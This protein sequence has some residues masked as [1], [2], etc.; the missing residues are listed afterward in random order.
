M[1]RWC[2]LVGFLS[3][4]AAKAEAQNWPSFRGPNGSGI[5]DDQNLPVSW[6]VEDSTNVLWK[7]PI[8][9]L[10]H[11]S[12][13]IWGDQVFLTTAI[14][15]EGTADLSTGEGDS[16]GYTSSKDLGR[17]TWLIYGLDKNTGKTLWQAA[18][19]DGDL[20]GY[21]SPR[22]IEHK[23]LR[24]VL[25]LTAKAMIGVNA[26]TGQLLWR[27]PHESYADENVLTPLFQDGH[28]F[29]S[30]PKAGS[31]KWKLNVEGDKA[32]VT[33]VWRSKELDSHHDGIILIADHIYG[34][35]RIYNKLQ[36]VCLNWEFGE[37]EYAHDGAGRG[38]VTYA[39]GHLY[40]Y[41]EKGVMAL[42][43]ATPQEFNVIS[44][45]DVPNQSEGPFWAHPVV[46]NGRLYLR[47]SDYLYVYDVGLE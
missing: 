22:L 38:S 46:C 2:F 19:A 36:W 4:F 8:A 32:S 11:S 33:E 41:S 39:D 35:S 40:T 26:D 9:G 6:N 27:F 45:F 28:I 7:T 13:I 5:A 18:S 15:R 37:K 12:P 10:A 21:A 24:I 1:R 34:A 47:H 23:G 30:T 14:A 20:A 44:K 42:V 16:A 43:K 29:V 31:V 17:Q 25:T 3:F